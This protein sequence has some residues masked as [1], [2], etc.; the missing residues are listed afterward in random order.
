M[1]RIASVWIPVLATLFTLP[2]H[3]DSCIPPPE[4][5]LAWWSFD[6]NVGGDIAHDRV[7]GQNGKYSTL[8]GQSKPQPVAATVGNGL[9]FQANTRGFVEVPDQLL[10]LGSGDFSIDFWIQAKPQGGVVVLL[11][12]RLPRFPYTGYHLWLFNGA[13]GLQLADAKG[14]TNYG[15]SVIVADGKPHF[16]A[17]T[18]ERN[19]GN[20]IHWYLDGREVL[21]RSNPKGR[22]GSLDNGQPLR[23]GAR[24]GTPSGFFD[25][26]LDELQIFERVLTPSEIRALSD[27]GSD[28][29]CKCPRTDDVPFAEIG[30]ELTNLIRCPDSVDC[31]N[32]T[33]VEYIPFGSLPK[34]YA[35][36]WFVES[37]PKPPIFDIALQDKI[38]AD[39]SRIGDQAQCSN[40]KTKAII[41]Y[42]LQV[43]HYGN[44]YGIFARIKRGC[45]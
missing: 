44:V 14:Y 9:R 18:V 35:A 10:N 42:Q 11:D 24:T 32:W 8:T 21:P 5:L 37:P 31:S 20:G 34:N 4:G 12:K 15:S 17:V 36:V 29:Q 43:N 7:Y 26:V 39:A 6:E 3:A 13:L 38:L 45:C 30:S 1:R 40:G 23:I 22:A 16:V 28:G 2:A 41:S 27:A 19:S 25:G 33:E